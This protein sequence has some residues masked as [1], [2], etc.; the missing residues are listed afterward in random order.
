MPYIEKRDI[1]M[2]FRALD[3]ESIAELF[4]NV[5][6]EQKILFVSSHKSLLYSF[7]TAITS[8]IFPFVWMHVFVPI[9]PESMTTALEAPFPFIMG[10]ES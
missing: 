1:E 5:L 3:T 10:I 8:F 2:L 7:A 9:I 6:L 4:L